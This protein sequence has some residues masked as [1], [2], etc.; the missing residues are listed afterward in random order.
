M[1][2]RVW[3]DDQYYPEEWEADNIAHLLWCLK[4]AITAGHMP[5]PSKLRIEPL[6]GESEDPDVAAH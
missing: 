4:D 2:Y 1:E 5:M 6:L 3:I